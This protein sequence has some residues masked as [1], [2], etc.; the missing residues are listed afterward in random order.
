[1]IVSNC[2]VTD[3]VF[4]MAVSLS[5]RTTTIIDGDPLASS[6]CLAPEVGSDRISWLFP[7]Q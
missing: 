1:M 7:Y 5:Q 2:K 4:E 6:S 3:A